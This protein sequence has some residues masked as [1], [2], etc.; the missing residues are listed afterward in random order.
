MAGATKCHLVPHAHREVHVPALV[1]YELECLGERVPF[2]ILSALTLFHLLECM[3]LA[4]SRHTADVAVPVEGDVVLLRCP[5]LR[6][7]EEGIPW[8]GA[9]EDLLRVLGHD[10]VP[11]KFK[12]NVAS[13]SLR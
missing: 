1:V 7:L 8:V 3:L 6:V 4:G 2:T 12:K 13:P 10:G 11:R 9:S 5:V